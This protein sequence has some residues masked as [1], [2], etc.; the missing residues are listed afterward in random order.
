MDIHAGH[1][2]RLR[3]RF[4]SEGLDSFSEHNVLE[5]I[6]FY[7]LP[8][9]DT[10]EIAH[11]LINHFGS[12]TAVLDAPLDEICKVKGVSYGTA[13]LI[14]SYMPVARYY[15][16]RKGSE[17]MVLDTAEK[18]GD[19]LL[20]CFAGLM[21]EKT[22]LLCLDSKCKLLGCATLAEGN[23]GNVGFSSRKLIETVIDYSA[24]GVILAHN[25]PS[26]IALPSESDL[27]ATKSAARFLRAVG[28]SLLD[29]IIIA[30]DDYVSMA[31]SAEYRQI[32]EIQKNF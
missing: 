9:I 14:K 7:A 12:F 18:C 23:I 17:D 4:L 29:H 5:L 11:A 19:Y 21:E 1:R 15:M 20:G 28:V 6:L 30:D 25:H 13:V 3:K 22:M 27:E 10:N 8:R 31:Q 26:G 24:S 16:A 32:F 2:N